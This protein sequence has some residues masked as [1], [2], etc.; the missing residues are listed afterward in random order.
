MS[1]QVVH[2]MQL[3]DGCLIC[4]ECGRKVQLYP[5]KVLNKGD[6]W[7]VHYFFSGGLQLKG[8]EVT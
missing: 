1:W 6:Q 8:L 2:E 7:A 5:H 4:S 3:I